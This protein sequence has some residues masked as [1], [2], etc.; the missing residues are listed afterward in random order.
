LSLLNAFR[1]TLT[2]II[3]DPSYPGQAATPEGVAARKPR[4]AAVTKAP[5]RE[6]F[7]AWREHPVTLFV[8]AALARAAK[9][10]ET[11]WAG[12]SWE[13]GLADQTLLNELRVRADAYNSMQEADYR[14]L[15]EWAGVP[16]DGEN[17]AA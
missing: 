17:S 11:A 13:G 2:G 14:G 5:T 12:T 7:D 16:G 4:L 9:E 3:A 6:A 1:H 8:F 10:Q 15:C